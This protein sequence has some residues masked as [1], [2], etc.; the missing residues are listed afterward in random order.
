MLKYKVSHLKGVINQ[1]A[2]IQFLNYSVCHFFEV[3]CSEVSPIIDTACTEPPYNLHFTAP[4]RDTKTLWKGRRE[5]SITDS[6][7][8]PCPSMIA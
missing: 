7:S 6:L 5:T 1:E 4:H 8:R 2:H 3:V